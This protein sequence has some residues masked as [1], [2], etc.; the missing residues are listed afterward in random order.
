[1]NTRINQERLKVLRLGKSWTQQNLA[2]EAKISLRSIQRIE[3]EGIASLQS[4]AAIA[5]AFC[6]EPTEL[7]IDTI[8]HSSIFVLLATLVLFSYSSF[9][10]GLTIFD[11]SVEALPVWSIP[12]IPS[13][14]ILIFG[15]VLQTPATAVRKRVYSIL[16]CVILAMLLSPPDPLRQ[17][18][19]T[20][21]LWITFEAINFIVNAISQRAACLS[22]PSR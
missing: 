4:R 7:E 21:A 9:Y 14:T 11:I 18:V 13:L 5:S 3:S 15:I 8:Q 1:M 19:Y 6:I 20:F 10:L 12:L 17:L 22:I 16:G 2:D